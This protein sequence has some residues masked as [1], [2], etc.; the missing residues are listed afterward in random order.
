MFIASDRLREE[1][2]ISDEIPTPDYETWR[3]QD[4]KTHGKPQTP[5]GKALKKNVEYINGE[6]KYLIKQRNQF[7]PLF[8]QHI[9]TKRPELIDLL[10]E[11]IL[12]IAKNAFQQKDAWLQIF[13][14]VDGDFDFKW[15]PKL[16]ISEITEISF[17]KE[18][19]SD[20]TGNVISDCTYPI[21]Y[22][23]RWGNGTGI[24][25]IRVDLK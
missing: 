11:E 19:T 5:F 4:A 21:E 16:S 8:I 25:N 1:F 18:T 12:E 22:I 7:M 20:F 15:S 3:N 2:K 6:K 9:Q 13:G 14:H 24:S 23:I 17:D 10:K